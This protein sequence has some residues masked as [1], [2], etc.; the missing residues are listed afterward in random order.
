MKIDKV[1]LVGR[2]VRLEPLVGKTAGNPEFIRLLGMI[3]R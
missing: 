2:H 3:H 1:A